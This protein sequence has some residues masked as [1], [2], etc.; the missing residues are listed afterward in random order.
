MATSINKK[1]RQFAKANNHRLVGFLVETER[2][3]TI[4]FEGC[5]KVED[6]EKVC[7]MFEEIIKLSGQ[8][9]ERNSEESGTSLDVG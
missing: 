2:K 9:K 8:V 5:V 7:K 4:Q 6:A 3:S 1:L